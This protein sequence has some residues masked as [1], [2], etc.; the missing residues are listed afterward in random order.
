VTYNSV[1]AGIGVVMNN[2]EIR[3]MAMLSPMDSG[4]F[5]RFN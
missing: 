5:L 2:S 3:D 1:C 4:A